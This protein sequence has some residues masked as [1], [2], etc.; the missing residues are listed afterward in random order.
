MLT[1]KVEGPLLPCRI[2]IAPVVDVVTSNVRWDLDNRDYIGP[3][4]LIFLDHGLRR[5]NPLS[6]SFPTLNLISGGLNHYQLFDQL[7]QTVGPTFVKWN[8]CKVRSHPVK[9]RRTQIVDIQRVEKI[10]VPLL[11]NIESQ[12]SFLDGIRLIDGVSG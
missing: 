10:D 7:V 2:K 11:T 6:N 8:E 3:Q 12:R 9:L 5:G 1:L 4:S